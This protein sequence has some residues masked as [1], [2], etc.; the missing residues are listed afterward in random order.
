MVSTSPQLQRE[1]ES[2]VQ[3]RTGRRVRNLAIEVAPERV[4]LKGDTATYYIKQLAQ[5]EIRDCL[6]H[7]HLDN[8]IVVHREAR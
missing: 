3:T 4:V 7:V 2:R 8:D 6:P 1:L 5:H